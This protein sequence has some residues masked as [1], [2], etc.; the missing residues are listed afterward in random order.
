MD[1]KCQPPSQSSDDEMPEGLSL[2]EGAYLQGGLESFLGKGGV[3]D[4]NVSKTRAPTAKAR[5]RKP[6][7]KAAPNHKAE[8]YPPKANPKSRGKPTAKNDEA[9]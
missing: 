2:V 3:A 6:R 5:T 9:A 1:V 7:G 8:R 4:H